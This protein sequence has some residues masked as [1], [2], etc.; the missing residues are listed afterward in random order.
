MKHS[1]ESDQRQLDS[2]KTVASDF[3]GGVPK[4]KK[5]NRGEYEKKSGWRQ[6][7]NGLFK[8]ESKVEAIATFRAN[9]GSERSVDRRSAQ[10]LRRVHI[11]GDSE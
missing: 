9:K 11:D 2:S 8:D 7:K 10:I 4:A 6:H 5:T 3:D 1:Q